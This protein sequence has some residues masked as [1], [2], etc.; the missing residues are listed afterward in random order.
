MNYGKSKSILS[1]AVHRYIKAFTVI[2][3]EKF[4]IENFCMKFII[5]YEKK[6]LKLQNNATQAL[7]SHFSTT[8]SPVMMGGDS[9][10]SSKGVMGVCQAEEGRTYLLVVV[11]H[12]IIIKINRI[13]L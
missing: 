2:L 8:A 10:A 3:Y 13:V 5:L 7:I 9:D 1:N 11:S 4:G 12:E 6:N